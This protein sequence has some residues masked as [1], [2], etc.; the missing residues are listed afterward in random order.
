MRLLPVLLLALG[1]VA[2]VPPGKSASLSTAPTVPAE[3]NRTITIAIRYEPTDLA[4][5]MISSLGSGANKQP[6]NASLAIIDSAG[7]ARPYLAETLPELHS[8]SW[9]V[10]PDGRMETRYRLR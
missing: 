8:E 9:Q 10:L 5:K 2:C 3:P 4:S 1:V 7:L 6:F